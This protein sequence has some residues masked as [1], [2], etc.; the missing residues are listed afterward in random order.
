MLAGVG[1]NGSINTTD[2]DQTF[3]TGENPNNYIW[4]SGKLWRAVSI[5]PKD[6]SVKLI[7]Q[8]NISTI[9]YNPSN[10]VS[11][12]GSYMEEWLNDT[13]VDGFLGNL[14]N[15]EE[16]IKTDSIWNA[17]QTTANTKPAQTTMVEDPV[18]LINAYEY[19]M[20]YSGSTFSNGYLNNGLFSWTVTP[21]SSSRI[22]TLNFGV[23]ASDSPTNPNGVRPMINLKSTVKIAGGDGT[24]NNP[25]RLS[26]DY[27]TNLS[28]TLLNT[29]YSG[30]Y[31]T[32]GIGENN[33]Y[34][35]VSHETNGLTKITSAE[36]LKDSGTF[37]TSAFGDNNIF[38][39]SNTI[40]NFL[41]N[42]YLTNYVGNVY[43]NMIEENTIWYLGTVAEEDS[44][45][46]AKYTIDNT[47]TS[48]TTT[49]K[50]GLLRLGELMAGQDPVME[51]NKI[52]WTLT[53][54]G[55]T[56]VRAIFNYGVS[57]GSDIS[58]K[59][60]MKPALNLK[61]NVVITSGKGTKENPF[62][63]ALAN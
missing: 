35:I 57:P 61:S 44:Y 18:G 9:N 48:N 15:Y 56:L 55:S 30:E 36:P 50:V 26:G 21:F 52:Y 3:I 22:R 20:S 62:Q 33:L 25:Y 6:N 16:F 11:F 10:N 39:S 14:R 53:P 45:K 42:E 49:T 24:E 38:S 29:R 4:Y 59:L 8:S 17:T 1:Q 23:I 19:T 5:D 46:L 27:D 43:N 31:I 12:S 28:G 34:R 60:A 40:G 2:P 41:N 47:I 58:F 32:F 54:K 7:T 63:I 13:S 51:E 37:R